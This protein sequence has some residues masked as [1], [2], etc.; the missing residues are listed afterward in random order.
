MR[1]IKFRAWLKGVD[2]PKSLNENHPCM[3]YP[4]HLWSEKIE[5]NEPTYLGSRGIT[6]PMTM[7]NLRFNDNIMMMQ[8]TG[9]K[10]KTGKEI[11][12][13]DIVSYMSRLKVITDVPITHTPL[14]SISKRVVEWKEDDCGFNIN[15]HTEDMKVIGNIY[16]NPE[17]FTEREREK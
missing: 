1:D 15:I 7:R 11:Y 13:G 16:E 3:S 9:M 6:I 4:F 5:F 17:L 8:Y 2:N 12:E 14:D 10:D